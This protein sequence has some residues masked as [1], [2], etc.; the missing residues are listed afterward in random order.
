[1][2]QSLRDEEAAMRKAGQAIKKAARIRAMEVAR[3][4]PKPRNVR[5]TFSK[6]VEVNSLHPS[7]VSCW[8]AKLRSTASVRLRQR[9]FPN[10]RFGCRFAEG[11]ELIVFLFSLGF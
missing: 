8:L 9:R 6:R 2:F 4:D 3:L 1:M 11:I 10:R 5:A 7:V